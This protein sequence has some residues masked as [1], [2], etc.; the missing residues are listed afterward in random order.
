MSCLPL[1]SLPS[2]VPALVY[3]T[4]RTTAV[5]RPGQNAHGHSSPHL[6]SGL[7]VNSAIEPVPGCTASK[8]E[9]RRLPALRLPWWFCVCVAGFLDVAE[10][11]QQVFVYGRQ[12]PT[13]CRERPAHQGSSEKLSAF[14]HQSSPAPWG[15][16]GPQGAADADRTLQPGYS[17][18]LQRERAEDRWRDQG[19]QSH[20]SRR[21][22]ERGGD[23]RVGSMGATR[24]YRSPQ[25]TTDVGTTR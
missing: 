3:P 22:R 23:D 7:P 13:L 16:T 21:F 9:P 15:R 10:T 20:V 17:L 18:P 19:W 2:P 1:L 4:A 14:V 24:N 11:R 6:L 5:P 12:G 25:G 8:V